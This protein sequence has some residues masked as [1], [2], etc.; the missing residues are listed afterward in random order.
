[1]S[2]LTPEHFFLDGRMAK[3]RVNTQGAIALVLFIRQSQDCAN[4]FREVSQIAQ[5]D[6]RFKL[7]VAQV[8]K[9]PSIP[10][11]LSSSASPITT[12]PYFIMYMQSS[13]IV[14]FKKTDGPIINKLNEAF[15]KIQASQNRAS[16][17]AAASGYSNRSSHLQLPPSTSYPNMGQA[18]IGGGRPWAPDI[19]APPA[20]MPTGGGMRTVSSYQDD[21]SLLESRDIVPHNVPWRV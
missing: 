16:P 10:K 2:E 4:T 9:Y 12:L 17:S 18:P 15:M 6:N 5:S 20:A 7:Y 14:M 11:L 19:G 21:D 1:M 3:L 13:P 8:D